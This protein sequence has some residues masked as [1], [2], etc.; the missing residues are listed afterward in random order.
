MAAFRSCSGVM[1]EIPPARRD[2]QPHSVV[3]LSTSPAVS[4]TRNPAYRRLRLTPPSCAVKDT[5]CRKTS[6]FLG[7][8]L[9]RRVVA[10]TTR[11]P[12][13]DHLPPSASGWGTAR[14]S[15]QTTD[16]AELH[17]VR[18]PGTRVDLHSSA[19]PTSNSDVFAGPRGNQSALG[20]VTHS[21]TGTRYP[22]PDT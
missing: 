10:S 13:R 14:I 17:S 18:A 3:C 7:R 12:P 5:E 8:R 6:P 9:G 2:A 19:I 4:R 22:V 20:A 1:P 21:G 15:V 11:S 16:V